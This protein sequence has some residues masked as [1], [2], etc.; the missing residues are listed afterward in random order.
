MGD[1]EE[2]LI[3]SRRKVGLGPICVRE[4]NETGQ[5]HYETPQKKRTQEISKKRRGSGK[6]IRF[7]AA[8]LTPVIF[9]YRRPGGR[10]GG[11]VLA[12]DS[13]AGK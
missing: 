3:R 9:K 6:K 8:F 1:G 10:E 12:R 2:G 7:A 11:F 5:S 4:R 13:T